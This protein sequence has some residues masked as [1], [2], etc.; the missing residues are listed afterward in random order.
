[1]ALSHQTFDYLNSRFLNPKR[2]SDS[3]V[4]FLVSALFNVSTPAT[5]GRLVIVSASGYSFLQLLQHGSNAQLHL[6]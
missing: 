6:L 1:M 4:G 5:F 2:K 3:N